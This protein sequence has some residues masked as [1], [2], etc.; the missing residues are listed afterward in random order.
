MRQKY[1]MFLRGTVHWVQDNT[2][3]KQESLGT[4]DRAEAKRLFN[5]KNE[6]HRQA[7]SPVAARSTDQL[8]PPAAARCEEYSR[9]L[10]AENR[11]SAFSPRCRAALSQSQRVPCALLP[12]P[13]TAPRHKNASHRRQ[14]D[15]GAGLSVVRRSPWMSN[16]IH[17]RSEEQ[18][19]LT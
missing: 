12:P 3:G 8:L 13:I 15:F 9:A 5:A 16:L 7:S 18:A 14:R 11:G 19:T 17:S 4:R 1:R 10:R 6:T 2:T